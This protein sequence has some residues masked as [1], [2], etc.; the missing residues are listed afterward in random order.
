VKDVPVKNESNAPTIDC[1]MFFRVT[2][3]SSEAHM[4]CASSSCVSR[5]VQLSSQ[6]QALKNL[7]LG[8]V[9]NVY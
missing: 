7:S 1:I 9:T 2:L 6:M 3:V 5:V 4:K 8:S